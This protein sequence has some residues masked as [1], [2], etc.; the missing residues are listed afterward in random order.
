ML[1]LKE[2][3]D[4]SNLHK[5]AMEFLRCGLDMM[6]STVSPGTV[7]QANGSALT[8]VYVW[9]NTKFATTIWIAWTDLTKK[10]VPLGY[11]HRGHG[12]AKKH[13]TALNN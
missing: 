4:A 8:V 3:P 7:Q 9:R 11:A 12:S 1:Y 6:K 10:I 13:I 2:L 5:F